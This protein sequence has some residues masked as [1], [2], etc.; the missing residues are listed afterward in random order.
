MDLL[1]GQHDLAGTTARFPRPG[2]LVEMYSRCVNTGRKLSDVVPIEY[3][4]CEPHMGAISELF[5]AFTARKRKSDLLDFDD[6]LLYW[7]ALVSR[8]GSGRHLSEGFEYVLVDE[9]QDVNELQVDI[10]RA[11]LPAVAA[12]PSWGTKDRRFTASGAQPRGTCAS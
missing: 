1:R 3:P 9:Y 12:S 5:R 10:V 2:T 4:W 6:L 11:W 8:E 7:R